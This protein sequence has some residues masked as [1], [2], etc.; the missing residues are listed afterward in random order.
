[1]LDLVLSSLVVLRHVDGWPSI[2]WPF[3]LIVEHKEG[4]GFTASELQTT[5]GET[6]RKVAISH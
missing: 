6:S 1:M 5:V 4:L 2:F 3:K